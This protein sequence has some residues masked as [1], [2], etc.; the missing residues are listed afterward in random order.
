MS[1]WLALA[2]A[3]LAL[4]LAWVV[5]GGTP[6]AWRATYI[7][8]A[9]AVA[10]ALWLGRPDPAG[11]P[12]AAGIPRDASLQWAVVDEPDP[13]TG[14]RGRIYLWLDVGRRAPRAFSIPYSR[15]LHEQ[16]QHAL[17]ARARGHPMSV[18]RRAAS[19]G[20]RRGGASG[21]EGGVHFYATPPTRL[22]PKPAA[23]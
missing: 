13:A 19:A 9:P 22:P 16:V 3:A 11:W 14:D 5:A 10:V 21:G 6:W 20:R 8:L 4:G 1:A 18:G 12:T 23:P 7:V 2:Y 17:A 15:P